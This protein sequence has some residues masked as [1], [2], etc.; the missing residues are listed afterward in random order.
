MRMRKTCDICNREFWTDA[1]TGRYCSIECRY[2]AR[3]A[4]YGWGKRYCK[5]N[6][7][8]NCAVQECDKCGWNPEVEQK[9]KEAIYERFTNQD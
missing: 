7:H 6:E 3:C 4:Q 5:F 1:F 8:V 9:R 2:E